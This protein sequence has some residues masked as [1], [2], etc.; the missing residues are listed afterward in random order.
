[1]PTNYLRSRVRKRWTAADVVAVQTR[2]EALANALPVVVNLRK[3]VKLPA[4]QPSK[5]GGKP[6]AHR[7][8]WN[9]QPFGGFEFRLPWAPSV[10]NA[11]VNRV[12]GGRKKS[13]RARQYAGLVMASLMEQRVPCNTLAHPM[14]ICITQH[15]SSDR[16][17]PDNGQKIVL[18][19]LKRYGVIADDNRGIIKDVR[20]IDGERVAPGKEFI[21]VHIR[22]I[23][24]TWRHT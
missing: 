16:G 19:C 14:G 24:P 11:Y 5:T 21:E 2:T 13:T 17:D 18:D 12:E 3:P 23:S 8:T 9:Y 15:A 4:P 22:C 20:V 10:N 7:A 6:N 1:M